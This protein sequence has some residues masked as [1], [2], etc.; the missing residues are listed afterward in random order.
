VKITL[1]DKAYE[2]TKMKRPAANPPTTTTTIIGH[3]WS[4]SKGMNYDDFDRFQTKY[5][6]IP[7]HLIEANDHD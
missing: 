3:G 7:E 6:G 2:L 4:E 5:H 1:T